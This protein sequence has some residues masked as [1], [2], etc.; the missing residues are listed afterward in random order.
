MDQNRQWRKEKLSKQETQKKKKI[1]L[2]EQ[3]VMAKVKYQNFQELLLLTH[4]TNPSYI[5]VMMMRK[6]IMI[7]YKNKSN[8][9][10]NK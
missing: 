10:N 7:I 2:C 4:K 5:K 6:L 3:I 9:N 1:P 8:N